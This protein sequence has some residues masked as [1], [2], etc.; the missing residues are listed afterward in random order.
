MMP[1]VASPSL[2]PAGFDA[3]VYVVLEEYAEIGR[4]C[5]ETDEQRADRETLIRHLIAGQY[6]HPVRIVAFNTAQG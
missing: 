1:D 6:D 3:D 5:R 4:A 2:V